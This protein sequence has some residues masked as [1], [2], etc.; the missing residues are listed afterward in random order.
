[1]SQGRPSIQTMA[2]PTPSGNFDQD[3]PLSQSDEETI[4]P[5]HVQIELTN[6]RK[7]IID[8]EDQLK[9]LKRLSIRELLTREDLRGE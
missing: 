2:A 8:L 7:R 3:N 4:L 5:R 9:E 6:G 1:M